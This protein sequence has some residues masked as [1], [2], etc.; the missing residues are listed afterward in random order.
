M[1]HHRTHQCFDGGLLNHLL[2][3]TKISYQIALVYSSKVDMDLVLFGTILHDIGKVK[4]FDAGDESAPIKSNL[5]DAYLLV[6]HVYLGQKIV[7]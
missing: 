3:V 4:I 6:A 5:N 1:Q 7:E 2:Q